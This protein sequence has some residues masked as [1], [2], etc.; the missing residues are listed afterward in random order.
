MKKTN[1]PK[2]I[3]HISF[4][5]TFVENKNFNLDMNITKKTS[6]N[7]FTNFTEEKNTNLKVVSLKHILINENST[8]NVKNNL[9]MKIKNIQ[10]SYMPPS[11]NISKQLT[12]IH[13]E[14]RKFFSDIDLNF[15]N[16]D[17]EV[18]SM[19]KE[20]IR[21][22]EIAALLKTSIWEKENLLKNNIQ[23]ERN[24]PVASK[25]T[26]DSENREFNL[27]FK[28]QIDSINAI[29]IIKEKMH[30]KPKTKDYQ[31]I[32]KNILSKDTDIEQKTIMKHIFHNKQNFNF[33]IFNGKNHMKDT[34]DA[35]Y[36]ENNFSE[37]HQGECM[38]NQ[39][40]NYDLLPK[41]DLKE[42]VNEN[43]IFDLEQYIQLIREKN[44]VEKM[45]RKQ[46]M[47]IAQ[48]II[49][50]KIKKGKLETINSDVHI[51]WKKA[52]DEFQVK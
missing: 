9:K 31:K 41:F 51:T 44:K 7:N 34:K 46:L 29:A 48:E 38:D 11:S 35:P 45:Y 8:F 5:N 10:K 4:P 15:R 52:K 40:N 50:Y 24:L 18:E 17:E 26:I 43:K 19:N 12:N 36:Q 1:K 47:Q 23:S 13:S 37:I 6:D 21:K 3:K 49:E 22:K 28:N 25:H 33:D 39:Q 14:K 16:L 42:M 30:S 27:N 2:H 32:F 20:I